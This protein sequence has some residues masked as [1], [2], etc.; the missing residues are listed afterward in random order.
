[1]YKGGSKAEASNYRPVSL[2]PLPGKIPE[3]IAHAR[4]S[5][6][7]EVDKFISDKQGEFRKGFS[8]MTSV[9]DLTDCLLSDTNNGLTSLVAFMDLR[10]AFDT[11]D[12][13]ILKNKLKYGIVD[14]NLRWCSNYF[15]NRTQKT[16]AN[17]F[18]SGSQEITC[19]VPQGS[20]LGS[21]FSILYVND[22]QNAVKGSNVQLYADGTVIYSSG[23][24]VKRA[25]SKSAT[26]KFFM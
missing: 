11:V 22:V 1:M 24:N 19:G 16:F 23:T 2:L 17:G 4:I 14:V 15:S 13:A 25:V 20:V 10:K 3:K 21:L 7:L 6:F 18:V 26:F 5:E 8:T 9:A 12:Q